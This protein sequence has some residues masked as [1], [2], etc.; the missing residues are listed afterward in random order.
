MTKL[1]NVQQI[2]VLEKIR[3]Q[4]LATGSPIYSGCGLCYNVEQQGGF[5]IRPALYALGLTFEPIPHYQIHQDSR[6]L[7]SGKQR[8]L[9][10][11]LIEK[12]ITYY[13]EQENA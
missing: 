4:V 13:Q 8:E 10:L 3:Q 1:E 11:A 9:R 12:L 6:T 5:C 7:W 2:Q